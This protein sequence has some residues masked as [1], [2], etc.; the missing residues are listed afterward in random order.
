M[1]SAFKKE[2][3]TLQ[4]YGKLPLAKDYLRVGAGKGNGQV[5]RDWMDQAYSTNADRGELP[6]FPWPVRFLIGIPGAD[7]I[8]G[9][10]WSSTDAGG[11]RPFPFAIFVERKKKALLAECRAGFESNAPVWTELEE[12]RGIIENVDNGEEFLVRMRGR[13]IEVDLTPRP[14]PALD[15]GA[16]TS[17]LWPE[18][19]QNGLVNVLSDVA[20]ETTGSVRS[21]IRLPL[22]TGMP[23]EPQVH[24]WWRALVALKALGDDVPTVFFPAGQPTGDEPSHVTFFRQAMRPG[25]AHWV[26]SSRRHHGLGPTDHGPAQPLQAEGNVTRSESASTLADSMKGALATARARS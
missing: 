4:L 7:P 11:H 9:V 8:Q 20:R 3:P 14:D 17:A 16:W 22:A 23:A 2:R 18:E 10:G 5:L 12:K 13:E 1:F 19:G 26:S 25:D 21:P 6:A 15:L 24:A